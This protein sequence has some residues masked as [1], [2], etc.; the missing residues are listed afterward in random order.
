MVV[1]AEAFLR[2]PLCPRAGKLGTQRTSHK[3]AQGST[4]PKRSVRVALEAQRGAGSEC[5]RAGGAAVSRS[6]PAGGGG[7]AS[8]RPDRAGCEDVGRA[9]GA[10]Q[11]G[12]HKEPD[13]GA[14]QEDGRAGQGRTRPHRIHR[15]R[16]RVILA[17]SLYLIIHNMGNC[18]NCELA[19][20]NA[21]EI[22]IQYIE[23][24]ISPPNEPIQGPP[25]PANRV[26]ILL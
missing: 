4:N 2:R 21:Q 7:G 9:G 8:L 24:I 11:W 23:R 22:T 25:M 18:E 19:R 1:E 14:A 15:Q 12:E 5:E 13:R 3:A 20:E 17:S 16:N 26:K 6:S 10:P